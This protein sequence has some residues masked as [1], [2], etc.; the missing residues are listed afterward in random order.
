MDR[1]ILYAFVVLIIILGF[2]YTLIPRKIFCGSDQGERFNVAKSLSP[3][4]PPLSAHNAN[5]SLRVENK[6]KIAK[7]TEITK[8]KS[9]VGVPEIPD[10][11][12]RSGI[13]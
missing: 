8:L 5:A 6:S 3:K 11:E 7:P 9:F 12:K 13:S 4:V 1:R 10:H 2:V